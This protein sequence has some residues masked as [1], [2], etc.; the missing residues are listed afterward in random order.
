MAEST[1]NIPN[2][3]ITYEVR[4]DG[5]IRIQ[6]SAVSSGF[7]TG[8]AS[9]SNDVNTTINNFIAN[10]RGASKIGFWQEAIQRNN[11]QIAT[12]NANLNSPAAL[13]D[14]SNPAIASAR[15]QLASLTATNQTYQASIDS[16]NA[17][18]ASVQSQG[19]GII[20]SLQQEQQSSPP[21]PTSTITDT[22]QPANTAPTGTN[23]LSGPASDDSGTQ[24]TT[25]ASVATDA[26]GTSTTPPPTPI[27]PGGAPPQP[28]TERADAAGTTSS[29]NNAGSPPYDNETFTRVTEAPVTTPGGRPGR[30]L[31]NP[32][33]S[34]AS[35]T[36]QL[37]LYMITASAYEAFVAGGRR[38]INLYSEE[39]AS[40]AT[41]EAQREEARTNGA[42][43]VAQSGGIGGGD[44]RAPG[45]EFD[46][47]IDNLSFEHLVASNE[48]GANVAQLNYKFQIIEPY[49]FSFLTQL[50]KAKDTMENSAKGKPFPRDPLR[51]FY[52]L[53][54]RFL[55]WDQNGAQITGSEIF[56]GNPIDP[57]A[58]GNGALFENF[59]DIS[60]NHMKFKLDGK[61]S[62]YNV[63]ASAASIEK[64]I[65]MRKG[66]VPQ[67]VT[68]SGSTVRDWLSGPNGL[69]TTLNKQQQDLVNNNTITHPIIYKINWL[70][71]AENIANSSILSE[72]RTDKSAQTSSDASTAA[73]VNPQT[74]TRTAPNNSSENFGVAN[75]PIVQAIDQIIAMS[76]YLQDSIA[77][78]YTDSNENN[79]ETAA[80]NIVTSP[81]KKFTWFHISPEISDIKW[82]GK[83]ND[84]AYTITY[85]IQTYLIPAID[86]P[87]VNNNTRY[88]GPHK[89]YDYW[90][91]GQNTQVL[92]F[93]QEINTGYMNIVAAGNPPGIA[94]ANNASGTSGTAGGTGGTAG[95]ASGAP[96]ASPSLTTTATNTTSP[97]NSD[98][99]RGT[100]SMEAIN[101][102]RTTLYDPSSYAESK[103]EILGDPDFLMQA[104]PS[105]NEAIANSNNSS[106]T[107]G[108][109]RFYKNNNDFTIS[110]TG[111]QV[112]FEI[113]F[114]EAV[115]YSVSDVNEQFADGK[116]VTGKGGTL[117]INDSINIINYQDGVSDKI[118]G[119][120]FFLKKITHNFKNGSF[121]QN[122]EATNPFLF[123]D[124]SQPAQAEQQ[125]EQP[126]DSAAPAGNGAATGT[127][128]ERSN[129]GTRVDPPA[130]AARPAAAPAPVIN[131]RTLFNR[132]PFADGYR[133]PPPTTT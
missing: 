35:Y 29:P 65:N 14:P 112:F 69:F 28:G 3:R 74:E 19:P 119:V 97:V 91:T 86:N 4:P 109:N 106:N 82:D 7:I 89:R 130:P 59:Y 60:I 40:T 33:G 24:P 61:A 47:Y 124:L 45:F 77:F 21:Q 75:I 84:W 100:L 95:G 113:D 37:S 27:L 126:A 36:Y 38:N 103:V 1:N 120:I 99:S 58:P 53:G 129:T 78:N 31:Q 121:T 9:G 80:P 68:V 5:T 10:V 12:L 88:Y 70:G 6:S 114:K 79:P 51:Q 92:K 20:A 118:N 73:E 13:A 131:E 125:R 105:L 63:D 111:G 83:I 34:L 55:G 49:G 22:A 32:L 64:T 94:N 16:G 41:T 67:N 115:D 11:I 72:G 66:M 15:A 18:I 108:F 93:E 107:A 8:I 26:A 96:A 52:I 56:D 127:T 30:R 87:F 2:G 50:R 57:S 102:V 48:T 110:A 81:D 46:Y 104:S 25:P 54:I 123:G 85:T 117:S 133:L 62:V 44:R 17:A 122:L 76:K 39:V 90:Y 116:G 132:G 98:G 43:L 71:E 128:S 101:S 23:T 42:F